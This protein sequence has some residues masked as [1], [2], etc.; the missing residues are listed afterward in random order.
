MKGARTHLTYLGVI[1]ALVAVLVY[2]TARMTRARDAAASIK[3][4][5][6]IGGAAPAAPREGALRS[7]APDQL[8]AE[9]T[10]DQYRAEFDAL[11]QSAIKMGAFDGAGGALRGACERAL[12]GGKRLR[13]ITLMEIARA[14]SKRRHLE[15]QMPP[16]DPADV[17]LAVEC[18]HAG[19]LVIDDLPAFDN[20]QTRRGAPAVWAE[21][22]EGT[23]MMA[24]VAMTA[25]A[26][27]GACRQVEWLRAH[28]AEWVNADRVGVMMC[29]RMSA[30][31]GVLGAAGGQLMDATPAA[32]DAGP[33]AADIIRRKTAP[34]YE[35][36]FTCGWLVGGADPADAQ[37]L[38]DLQAAGQHFGVAFQVADDIG[39]LERDRARR[40]DG[41]TV[42]NYAD[43]YGAD[44]AAREVTRRIAACDK[45]LRDR[46]LRTPLWGEIFDK[47]RGMAHLNHGSPSHSK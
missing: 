23:A 10:F 14:V 16:V 11:V 29:D 1:V 9:R 7:L 24:A 45:I 21:S 33:A 31:L 2:M 37:A 40:A 20:D 18:F 19:S 4:R 34:F 12:S 38:D 46:G 13:P 15:E 22:G 5:Y 42:W 36:A 39:D 32:A 8:L 28:C 35:M 6:G 41:K 17:A 27:Q 30:A 26:F 43:A 44:E 25:G 3:A 47:V